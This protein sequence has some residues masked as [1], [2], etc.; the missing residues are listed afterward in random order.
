[1]VNYHIRAQHNVKLTLIK[2]N[3]HLKLSLS[4]I[5]LPCKRLY[6]TGYTVQKVYSAAE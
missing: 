5:E 6:A 4:D 2:L 1:M 3:L